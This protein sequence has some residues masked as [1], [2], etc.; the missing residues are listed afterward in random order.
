MRS[1]A[2]TKI[3]ELFSKAG[4]NA[5]GLQYSSSRYYT[6]WQCGTPLYAEPA[7]IKAD[8]ARTRK[9]L[10]LMP[11]HA[12]G[13]LILECGKASGVS[14]LDID[15]GD[16]AL[17]KF[18]ALLAEKF[19][20]LGE[21]PLS[22]K[23]ICGFYRTTSRGYHFY[24][25]YD[26]DL[27]PKSVNLGNLSVDWLSDRRGEG[28]LCFS[29]DA[30]DA[31]CAEALYKRPPNIEDD[32]TKIMP[33]PRALKLTL[34]E[35]STKPPEIL[36]NASIFGAETKIGD[37]NYIASAALEEHIE[38]FIKSI[39]E[40]T[41]VE[42]AIA[43]SIDSRLGCGGTLIEAISYYNEGLP[44]PQGS[45]GGRDNFLTKTM[46]VYFKDACSSL[47]RGE[48]FF[49]A[50]KAMLKYYGESKADRQR[51]D[52]W[53]EHNGI[54]YFND[55]SNAQ[56][57]DEY[58]RLK[59]ERLLKREDIIKRREERSAGVF[60]ANGDTPHPS[61]EL[62]NH[63]AQWSL[64]LEELRAGNY[65][66][67]GYDIRE[68]KYF[69]MD[70]RGGDI[71]YFPASSAKKI[72]R[73]IFGER[74]KSVDIVRDI[75]SCKFGYSVGVNERIK[76]DD[77]ARFIEYNL[78]TP[79][80]FGSAFFRAQGSVVEESTLQSLERR[81]PLFYS[82]LANISN[83][84]EKAMMKIM[85]SLLATLRHG[86]F[87]HSFFVLADEVGGTGKS[88]FFECIE[89]LLGT[90]N[91]GRMEIARFSASSQF[92]K[93]ALHNKQAT[94][95][96]EMEGAVNF[97]AFKRFLK[98]TAGNAWITAQS[99]GQDERK[100][101]NT[102]TIWISTNS[103]KPL[104]SENGKP[105]RR[106]AHI[107]GS[108]I[109]LENLKGWED[110]L[111]ARDRLFGIE[112]REVALW[113]AGLSYDDGI[114]RHGYIPQSIAD[115]IASE[116]EYSPKNIASKIVDY[117]TSP[118]DSEAFRDAE[119]VIEDIPNVDE[120][121]KALDAERKK[122][123]QVIAKPLVLRAFGKGEGKAII[124]AF[125]LRGYK[126]RQQRASVYVRNELVSAYRWG[127]D[128]S[129]GDNGELKEVALSPP[130]SRPKIE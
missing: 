45:C 14:V 70:E 96:E 82:L 98:Q 30:K 129:S 85:Q 109:P 13:G 31:D 34:W 88:T 103:P 32:F 17:S 123:R 19:G 97:E 73:D 121:I 55:A 125:S 42:N 76:I 87:G 43:E 48:A 51:L 116:E 1:V 79:S 61:E 44:A 105:N 93:P 66:V 126:L 20:T 118:K 18:D 78:Y 28:Q 52:G 36:G 127:F 58:A 10:S 69:V 62:H 102:T 39:D 80:S 12:K 49:E 77:S 67:I 94:F 81:A 22:L 56:K 114:N 59:S 11:P 60:F 111:D 27:P 117:L 16:E 95:I 50:L 119:A 35:L 115:I 47:E 25:K 120:F 99:K 130:K 23:E 29:F 63:Y 37:V 90:E 86:Y 92:L 33:V 21:S 84:D 101:K 106:E 83:S 2:N 8:I 38:S 46:V 26:A 72:L 107:M 64:W 5:E 4:F 110:M 68:C 89:R 128:V 15:G 113:L 57:R 74:A 3:I 40:G 100:F 71:S 108:G 91:C 53:I 104:F 24:F 65:P 75:P 112:L 54:K 9:S 41:K 124:S 6:Q 122:E 7:D